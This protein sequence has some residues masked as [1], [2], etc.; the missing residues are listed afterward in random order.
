MGPTARSSFL[1]AVLLA[2]LTAASCSSSGASNGPSGSAAPSRDGLYGGS[3]TEPPVAAAT[4]EPA[5]APGGASIML[6]DGALG[7]IL[8]DAEGRTLYGFTVDVDGVSA[9]Y[10]GCAAAWPPLVVDGPASVG[11]GLDGTLLSTVPRTDGTTQVKYGEWPLY[12]FAA[13]A[14]AGETKGQGVNGVWYVV[15]ADGAL[16]GR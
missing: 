1:L 2:A 12:Y 8:V 16:I 14:S 10:D 13:D 9:C 7:S 6:A 15:G 3:T 11:D 5:T 4:E